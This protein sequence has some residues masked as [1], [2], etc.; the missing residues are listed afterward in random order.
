MRGKGKEK[1][2][3]NLY[4]QCTCACKR[5]ILKEKETRQG[6]RIRKGMVVVGILWPEKI[7]LFERRG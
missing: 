7:K 2:Q 6:C 3:K 4:A 5:T 1:K